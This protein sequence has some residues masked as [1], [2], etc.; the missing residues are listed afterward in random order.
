MDSES[1]FWFFFNRSDFPEP[2]Y[3]P[4]L[5]AKPYLF[6]FYLYIYFIFEQ[7]YNYLLYMIAYTII[8][9]LVIMRHV[10]NFRI[11]SNLPIFIFWNVKSLKLP[12]RDP[13]NIV[14]P[15]SNYYTTMSCRVR[16]YFS[17]ICV[18]SSTECSI[19]KTNYDRK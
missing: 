19:R 14:T 3:V 8:N 17:R 18:P 6:L 10:T 16:F 1:F 4:N 11:F 2:K 7:I 9:I 15:L 12:I 5:L 13:L